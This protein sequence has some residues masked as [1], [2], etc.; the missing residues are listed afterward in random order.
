MF[1]ALGWI[2]QLDAGEVNFITKAT[3]TLK[4]LIQVTSFLHF[5][6]GAHTAPSYT[7]GTDLFQGYFKVIKFAITLPEISF[8]LNIVCCI[9]NQQN[10]II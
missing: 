4:V 2:S 9:Q 8:Q 10:I 7:G 3:V 1:Q 5:Q 6:N